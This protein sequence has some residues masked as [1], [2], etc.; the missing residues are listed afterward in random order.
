MK[1]DRVKYSLIGEIMEEALKG[2]G[3]LTIEA[4]LPVEF[5]AK[6][7]DPELARDA[8]PELA[9]VIRLVRKPKMMDT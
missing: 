7:D 3:E 8:E 4:T 6:S 9:I 5:P 2:K 1:L